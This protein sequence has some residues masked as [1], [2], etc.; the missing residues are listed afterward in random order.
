MGQ[1]LSFQTKN[2]SVLPHL[3][4]SPSLSPSLSQDF[5]AEFL[6]FEKDSI[7]GSGDF[8]LSL[9]LDFEVEFLGF[10]KD[11]ILDCKDCE[12]G[13]DCEDCEDCEDLSSLSLDFEGLSLFLNSQKEWQDHKVGENTVQ[14][15]SSFHFFCHS[16]PLFS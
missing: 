11:S 14:K 15:A 7:L 1:I 12:D 4:L 3:L 10:E 16:F 13:E 8:S 9:S 5:S 6:G 2:L